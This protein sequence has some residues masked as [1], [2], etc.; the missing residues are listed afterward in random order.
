MRP[1]GTSTRISWPPRA[2]LGPVWQRLAPIG[3]VLLAAAC[4][5]VPS[6]RVAT[7][8][9]V[10]LAPDRPTADRTAQLLDEMTERLDALGVGLEI[11]PLEVWLFDD[12][13][14]GDVY[15]GYDASK[16]RILLDAHRR[17]PAATLAHELVHAYEPASWSRLPAAVREGIADHLAARAVPEIAAEMRAARAISLASYAIGGLPVSVRSD[18]GTVQLTR[19]GVP[20]ETD[21]E[22]LEI[23]AIPHGRIRSAGDGQTLKAIYGM[24]LLIVTRAGIE[25]LVALASEPGSTDLVAPEDV[26]AAAR[27]SPDAGTWGPA[28]DGLLEGPE[29]RRLVREMLGLPPA[30][31]HDSEATDGEMRN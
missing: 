9:G 23:L 30:P 4:T 1:P 17:H 15:G 6:S 24:G 31:L 22:P 3:L 28:I 11:R 21:L 5:S 8:N 27:L 26:L 18:S 2:S 13:H 19:A 20:V 7:A 16:R 14:D 10:V 12:L 29:E 25:P